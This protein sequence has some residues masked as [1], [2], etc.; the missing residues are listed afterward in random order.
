[1]V[2]HDQQAILQN[3]FIQVSVNHTE[4]N[5]TYRLSGIDDRLCLQ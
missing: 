2:K 5:S 4:S 3:M 1:M